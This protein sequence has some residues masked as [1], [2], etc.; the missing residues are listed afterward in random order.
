M[1]FEACANFINHA[2]PLSLSNSPSNY[3]FTNYLG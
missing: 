3:I 2:F 1:H